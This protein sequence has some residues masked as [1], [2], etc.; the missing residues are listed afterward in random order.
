LTGVRLHARTSEPTA[1]H[2]DTRAVLAGRGEAA[3]GAPL[4]RP[5]VFASAFRAG[6]EHT[7][8]RD[9][10]PTW[11]AFEEA[12]GALEGGTAVAFSTGMGAAAAAIEALPPTAR[13]LLAGATYVEV[14]RLLAEREAAGRLRLIEADA[15]DTG[16][17]VEAI[18]D[19]DMVWL[20][21]ISNPELEVA[22]V[23]VI[24]EAARRHDAVMIVDATLA[25][26]FNQRPLELGADLVIHSA[27]KYIGGHS[28]LLLGVAVAANPARAARLADARTMLGAVPGTL[29]AWLGLRGL[30]TLPLRID[31]G[32]DSARILAERLAEHPAVSRVRYPGL[33]TDP[34]HPVAGRV[35]DGYGA[36]LCFE[37]EGGE[38]A[39]DSVCEEVTVIAHAGSFGG[40]ETLIERHGRWHPG[41]EVPGGL[42]RLSV[43]C[44]HPEDLWADLERALASWAPRTAKSGRSRQH[45]RRRALTA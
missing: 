33:P 41:S 17:V 31:R 19:A 24:A 13:V 10:N 27:T 25:T 2:G 45:A 23:D 16:A 7:Y 32:A 12:L 14:R 43:G 9:G 40:V 42:L 6:G 30:R 35:L 21:S 44:E 28:D 18:A 39:A 29:E 1:L 34:A 11:E 20:D 3:P 4:N 26:P 5:P 8:S 15:S 37:V 36:L 22:E 38:R